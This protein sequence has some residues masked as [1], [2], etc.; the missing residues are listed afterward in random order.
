MRK[1]IVASTITAILL[2]SPIIANAGNGCRN[3]FFAVKNDS[4]ATIRLLDVQYRNVS[5]GRT[6]R[7]QFPNVTCANNSM[8]R[9]TN[10]QLIKNAKDSQLNDF[11]FRFKYLDPDTGRWSTRRISDQFK[12]NDAI[13]IANRTYGGRHWVINNANLVRA[14]GV[15]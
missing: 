1:L 10:G 13:C 8:C 5:T 2:T 15:L 11:V 12:V 4:G 14:L 6:K 9:T 7:E 3:I